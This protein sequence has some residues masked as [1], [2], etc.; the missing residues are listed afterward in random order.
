MRNAIIWNAVKSRKFDHMTLRRFGLLALV[1]ISSCT[2]AIKSQ[3]SLTT[4]TINNAFE[5][6]ITMTPT[7]TASP[8]PFIPTP[9]FINRVCSPLKSETL[10]E[11]P[12]IITQSYSP[13]RPGFDEG[14]PGI[15]FSF[16]R[17]KDLL[18]IDGVPV[19]SV[20][21][22]VV[23]TIL[24]DKLPYGHAIIIETP[25]ENISK[26]LLQ[27]IDL[28][29]IQPTME[30]DLKFN[31]MPPEGLQPPSSQSMSIYILYAHL[32]HSVSLSVGEEVK[33]GQE[34]GAVGDSGK[35]YST[36][37]HL[38]FETRIGPS[39]ARF[40]SMAYYTVDSTAAERY[41]YCVWRVSNTFQSFDPMLLL[42]AQE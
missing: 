32:K 4:P 35:E 3:G 12:E 2:P 36:N 18:S 27:R 40:D 14:H 26:E 23:V 24:V 6:I 39:G 37:P 13:S 15:D 30:P 20:L 7:V 19:L 29:E 28:P 25:L 16:F 21:D 10:S 38:H 34:I 11:L 8:I 22:G 17:R 9:D 31:C 41:N 1:F 42:S 5:S 33:C